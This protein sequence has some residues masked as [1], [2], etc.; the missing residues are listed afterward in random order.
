MAHSEVLLL[1]W[2]VRM[3]ATLAREFPLMNGF[4]MK[5]TARTGNDHLL[6]IEQITPGTWHNA[7]EPRDVPRDT[8]AP[9]CISTAPRRSSVLAE[10]VSFS[11]VTRALLE[12]IEA[13]DPS[14][15][16]HSDRVSRLSRRLAVAAGCMEHVVDEATVCGWLH[17]IGKIG[18]PDSILLKDGPLTDI[19]FE[20][21][22]RHPET[23]ERILGCMP[24]LESIRAG[25]RSHHERWDGRGYP[26]GISGEE[27]P[28]LGRIVC[29]ADAFDAMCSKRRYR[30]GVAPQEALI[31]I[32]RNAGKQ[33]DPFLAS[34]FL[35][36][37]PRQEILAPWNG[38]PGEAM[39]Q[40][41]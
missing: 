8:V 24:Q 14:T 7:T 18:V 5:T 37:N 10:L 36:M 12:T 27:I 4:S 33:F 40:S 21:I 2:T 20:T 3:D 28:L 31:E 9:L 1:D 32:A 23:G 30:D 11:G 13:K 29:I 38:L 15:R 41:A 16:G 17:D 39:R 22:K 35:D 34:C 6:G 26:D 19:E 25:V